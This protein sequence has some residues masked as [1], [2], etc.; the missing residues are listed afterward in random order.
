MFSLILNKFHNNELILSREFKFWV[1]RGSKKGQQ[2]G[3]I[4]KSQREKLPM[5][6]QTLILTISHQHW[7]A[8]QFQECNLRH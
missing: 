1:L 6:E 8:R 7:K 5:N 4:T 2:L 3:K